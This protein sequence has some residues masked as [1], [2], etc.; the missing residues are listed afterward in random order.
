MWVAL[1]FVAWQIHTPEEKQSRPSSRPLLSTRS[2]RSI[3][4]PSTML[5][6][7]MNMRLV[8]RKRGSEALED[9]AED[10]SSKPDQKTNGTPVKA[11]KSKPQTPVSSS[12]KRHP[13]AR[14]R[15]R[16]PKPEPVPETPEQAALS[17]LKATVRSYPPKSFHDA[18]LHRLDSAT[19]EQ[20]SVLASLLEGLTPPLQ[21]H[22]ARCHHDYYEEDNGDRSCIMV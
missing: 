9:D 10:A 15:A 1:S 22:C 14:S 4:Y 18:L 16:T 21:L 19:P 12:A 3:P 2:T 8:G 7:L 13:R 6:G 11:I 5:S 17:A 20:V